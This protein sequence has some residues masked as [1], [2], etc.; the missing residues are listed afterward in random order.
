M[1][2]PWILQVPVPRHRS[3]LEE[4]PPLETFQGF[5]TSSVVYHSLDSHDQVYREKG[6]YYGD[7]GV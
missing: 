4:R 7:Y 5:I 2:R 6:K 1:L 3:L